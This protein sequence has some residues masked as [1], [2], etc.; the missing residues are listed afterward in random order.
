MHPQLRVLQI[1][2]RG[3][4]N[5]EWMMEILSNH[6]AIT[7]AAGSPGTSGR[8]GR[9]VPAEIK[10]A[11]QKP[12]AERSLR[13]EAGAAFLQLTPDAPERGRHSDA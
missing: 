5:Q 12:K 6:Q 4:R 7:R 13:L 1:T 10:G 2:M 9:K 3:M 8:I 11:R